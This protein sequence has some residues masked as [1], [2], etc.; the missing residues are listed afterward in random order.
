MVYMAIRPSITQEWATAICGTLESCV[1]PC[2]MTWRASA[3]YDTESIIVLA[4]SHGDNVPAAGAG[5]RSDGGH[6]RAVQIDFIKP[7]L[8]APGP[9]RLKPKYDEPA[10]KFAFRFNLRRY[11]MV[12]KIEDD[13]EDGQGL[14]LVPVPAQVEL[15]LP[16]SAKLKLTLSPVCPKSSRVCVPKVLRLRFNVSDVSRRCSS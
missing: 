1:E 7:T 14:T 9:K 2:P 12:D 11:D 4:L 10:S 5:R 8:K 3:T 16:L 6:G 13:A 15:T